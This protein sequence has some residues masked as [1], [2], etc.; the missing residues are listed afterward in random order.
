MEY[1]L[2]EKREFENW[3]VKLR[4]D[5]HRYPEPGWLEYR[6]TVRIIEELEQMGLQI[7]QITKIAMKLREKGYPLP[8]GVLTVDQAFRELL[9]IM[10]REEKKHG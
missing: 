1:D 4:R 10:G 8:S 5:F 3:L 7:P 6:T 2:L 9:Q